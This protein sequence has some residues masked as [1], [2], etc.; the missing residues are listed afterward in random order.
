MQSVA[1][2]IEQELTRQTLVSPDLYWKFNPR[3]LYAYSIEAII[4]AGGA[5]VD[6]MAMSRNEWRDWVGLQPDARMDELLALENYVPINRLGD[7]KK[8]KGGEE[9][10]GKD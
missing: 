4:A 3:S 8:L 9:G 7:Q 6:R 1:K 2:A 5:M 10:D